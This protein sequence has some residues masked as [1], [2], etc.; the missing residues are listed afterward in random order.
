[1][2]NLS[3]GRRE[4][5]RLAHALTAAERAVPAGGGVMAHRDKVPMYRPG[6]VPVGGLYAPMAWPAGDPRFVRLGVFVPVIAPERYLVHQV[7]CIDLVMRTPY[8]DE[9]R[10]RERLSALHQ[11]FIWA[12]DR[13][14][15][16]EPESLLSGDRIDAFIHERWKTEST[17]AT[18]RTRL[19][20][21]AAVV[22]PP[23]PE[24]QY[25][26]R[27]T[28]G[29]HTE[30]E[31]T[32][33]LAASASLIGGAQRDSAHRRANHRETQ[34]LLAISFGAGAN[35]HEIHRIRERWL[36]EDEHGWWLERGRVLRTPIPPR[37]MA[38]IAPHLT[39]DPQAFLLRPHCVNRRNQQV[40]KVMEKAT[41]WAP[42]MAGFTADR[43][44]RHW[45]HQVLMAAHFNVV[46]ALGGY[47]R[48]TA[49]PMDMVPFIG[50]ADVAAAEDIA[51]GWVR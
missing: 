21:V 38:M 40:G 32:R 12:Q 29:M 36:V 39:G 35:G 41:K 9:L 1:M 17:R 27:E 22:F 43:A 34:V 8:V 3:P 46:V 5:W 26:R 25:K 47:N 31:L 49:L 37:W 30:D 11:L 13:R 14:F 15:S 20:H 33:F 4:P 23:A 51:R 50:V 42:G 45:H 24:M 28:A 2:S 6:Q 19:R 44:A 18:M 10:D 48:D 7:R 16:C